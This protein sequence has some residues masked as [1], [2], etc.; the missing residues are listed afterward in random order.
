MKNFL[1]LSVLLLTAVQ[2]VPGQS[3]GTLATPRVSAA[4][5]GLI[6]SNTRYGSTAGNQEI[7][8]ET[9]LLQ[10]ESIGGSPFLHGGEIVVDFITASDSLL[11]DVRI[12]YDSYN[13]E[14]IVHRE[15]GT[16]M[17]LDQRYYK[18]FLYQQEG[19]VE[20]YARLR[21]NDP[22]FYQVLF[23][24]ADFVF[25]KKDKTTV[26]ADT[27]YVPGQENKSQKFFHDTE[28]FVLRGST[29]TP[30]SLAKEGLIDFLPPAYQTQVPRIKEQLKIRR[31]SKERDYIT[32]LQEIAAP[33]KA[34]G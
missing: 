34:G 2:S 14:I 16:T 7:S 25:C 23:A 4:N 9:A 15:D 13:Q 6:S 29:L 30:V 31:L 21:P 5:N 12:R 1:L 24:A 17:V 11:K 28:Y 33:A 27:R 19:T 3:G 22:M 8:Y 20:H 18:G 32:V 26:I 10:Y